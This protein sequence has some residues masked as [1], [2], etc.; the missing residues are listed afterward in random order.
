[1]S[2]ASLDYTMRHYLK[3]IK[4][5]KKRKRKKEKNERSQKNG[6]SIDNYN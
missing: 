2:K 6:R 5:K 4:K 1:V 3:Q